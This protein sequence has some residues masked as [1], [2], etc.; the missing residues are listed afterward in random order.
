MK[1]RASR[2]SPKLQGDAGNQFWYEAEARYPDLQTHTQRPEAAAAN[3]NYALDI[4]DAIDQ[5]LAN[6]GSWDNSTTGFSKPHGTTIL[7]IR[8]SLRNRQRKK[9]GEATTK[10]P[11]PTRPLLNDRKELEGVHRTTAELRPGAVRSHR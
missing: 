6:Y 4:Q 1:I 3:T 9:N 5:L 11:D 10:T 7:K 2:P 8:E